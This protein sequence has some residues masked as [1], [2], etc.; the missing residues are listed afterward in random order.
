MF[1]GL[2]FL[3]FV[4]L[5][6]G[7]D[8]GLLEGDELLEGFVAVQP[9]GF[10]AFGIE[11]VAVLK[12]TSLGFEARAESRTFALFVSVSAFVPVFAFG[13]FVT[14]VAE[15]FAPVVGRAFMRVVVASGRV[16]ALFVEIA[17]F[18]FELL[19]ASVEDFVFAIFTLERS[20]PLNTCFN[21]LPIDS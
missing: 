8:R 12:G 5:V 1:I 20:Y 7:F 16:V 18:A 13:T 17:S 19:V 14:T 9:F 4:G 10:F 15:A 3:R 2:W 21:R 11:S 6:V